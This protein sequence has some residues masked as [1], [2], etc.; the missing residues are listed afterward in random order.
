MVP[1]DGII[2]VANADKDGNPAWKQ[3]YHRFDIRKLMKER[4]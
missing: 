4:P 1:E 3:K 2:Y